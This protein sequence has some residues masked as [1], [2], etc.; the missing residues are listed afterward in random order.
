MKIIFLDI[1]GV[2]NNM[3]WIYTHPDREDGAHLSP[4]HVERLTRLVAETGAKVVVSS[5]WRILHKRRKLQALLEAKGFVGEVI[6]RTSR[7]HSGVRGLQILEWLNL[8]PEVTR[9]VVLDDEV[10]DLHDLPWG[11]V[12]KTEFALG[13]LD[14]HVEQAI[15][16]LEGT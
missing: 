13:L 12:V 16:I 1:D 7:N 8:H 15:N 3:G 4:S 2:L 6:G 14:I 11:H 5:T 10:S 9:W